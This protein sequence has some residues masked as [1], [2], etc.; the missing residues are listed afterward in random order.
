ML[1]L[2]AFN[3]KDLDTVDTAVKKYFLKELS[4]SDSESPVK[5]EILIGHMLGI[6]HCGHT[7]GRVHPEM[8]RKLSELDLFLA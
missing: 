5:C 4:T 6:D 1:A 2:P 3:I 8:D 7:Y